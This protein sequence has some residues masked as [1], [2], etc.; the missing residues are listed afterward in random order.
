MTDI[1]EIPTLLSQHSFLVSSASVKGFSG[2]VGSG[3]TRGLC[4]QALQCALANP[5]CVGLIG[6]PTYP[7]L[8][9]VTLPAMLAFFD[10]CGVAYAYKANNHTLTLQGTKSQILFRSLDQPERLRG[11]NLAWVGV[12]ELTYCKQE[13]WLRLEARVRDPK[14]R[15]RVMF[16]V[17]TPKGFDWVYR[18]FISTE[19]LPNHEAIL[20][21]PN[22][23]SFMLSGSPDYYERLKTSYDE[24]FYQ[25]EVL[26]EYLNVHSGRAYHSFSQENVREDLR[27]FEHTHLCWSL[28]FNVDPM[29]SIIGQALDGKIHVL[30]EISIRDANTLSMC[31]HFE[32]RAQ[33]YLE[34][35][36][37]THQ[38]PLSVRIYGDASGQARSTAS[39]T[40]YDLIRGYFR[41]KPEFNITL[42]IPPS[43][44]L[45][46]DRVNSV[47]ALFKNANGDRK[48]F[49]RPSCRE[50]II[51]LQE[52]SWKP[53]DH[54]Q[55][56]KSDRK[57]THLSDALG[58]LVWRIAPINGFQR[59]NLY[60]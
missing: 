41:S 40:D 7:M 9:D 37:K 17:W 53:G 54:F 44:P 6:A 11:A 55:L 19:K 52:V 42:D 14:A 59:K 33:K 51:D 60:N 39:K 48:L 30:E 23:N 57:R 20:A 21:K 26:G 27:F 43:N 34:Q 38:R 24:L 8:D 5:G 10:E 56:D 50:L 29:T 47:N 16:A 58:Y 18:R 22:E 12:D 31:E 3:K 25:Q 36:S 35:N 13:A 46:R 4:Y 1:T 49:I 45:V 28:D 15:L 32:S 2:P